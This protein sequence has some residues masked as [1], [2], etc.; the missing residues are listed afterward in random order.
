MTFKLTSIPAPHRAFAREECAKT[1]SEGPGRVA[2][3]RRDL[4]VAPDPS[5]LALPSRGKAAQ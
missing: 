4:S 5:P 1:R 2:Y 3:A